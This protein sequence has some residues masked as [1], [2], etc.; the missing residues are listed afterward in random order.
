VNGCAGNGTPRPAVKGHTVGG[1]THGDLPMT[2][3]IG[4]APTTRS[5]FRRAFATATAV[6][7]A[8]A[9]AACTTATPYQPLSSA[10]STSGGFAER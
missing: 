10:S 2:K 7:L 8:A 3:A 5:T 1:L 4:P 9:V 6:A